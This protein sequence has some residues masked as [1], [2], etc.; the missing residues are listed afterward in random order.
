MPI[1]QSNVNNILKAISNGNHVF[2]EQIAVYRNT[3]TICP[4]CIYDPI[5]KESTD[6]NCQTCGG[7]GQIIVEVFYS[8]PASVE[9]EE[10]FKYDFSRAGRFVKGEILVTIDIVELNT[11]LNI[12][13]PFDLNDYTQLKAF[14]ERY[15]YIKWKGA[16]YNIGSFE[17]GW[18][19]GNLYELG[20]VLSLME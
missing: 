3:K 19:E 8:I 7:T 18:L 20:L 10:D 9:T 6:Y 13:S 16:K 15:D 12:S 4:N 5:R 11:V 1:S 17:P 14:I 2:N